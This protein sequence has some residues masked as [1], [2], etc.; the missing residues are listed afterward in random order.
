MPDQQR[1]SWSAD[2]WRPPVQHRQ[3]GMQEAVSGFDPHFPEGLT[4]AV[5][6]SL[7]AAFGRP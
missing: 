3:E 2:R 6:A 1:W 7:R 5:K 4:G